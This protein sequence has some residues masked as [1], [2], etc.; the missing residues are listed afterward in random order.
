VVAGGAPADGWLGEAGAITDVGEAHEVD[1]HA[2]SA[3]M[4]SRVARTARF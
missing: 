1:R 4:A 3:T 2:T